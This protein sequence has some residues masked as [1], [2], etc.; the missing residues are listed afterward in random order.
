MACRTAW[1]LYGVSTATLMTRAGSR[2]GVVFLRGGSLPTR[3]AGPLTSVEGIRSMASSAG[4]SAVIVARAYRPLRAGRP[5]L[6]GVR[7]LSPAHRAR[8]V[9]VHPLLMSPPVA[10]AP[11]LESAVPDAAPPPK[12][13]SDKAGARADAL[14]DYDGRYRF[15]PIEEAQVARAMIKRY[16]ATLYERAVSDVVIV[17]AGSAGLSCAYH[18]A[19]ARPELKI[20]IVEASVAPGGGA[21]L[22]GQLMTP[23][24]VRKP[25]DRFLEELGVPFEDEG[26]FVVVK[27][28][29]LFTA[30]VLAHVLRMPNVVLLNATAVEDLIV[31]GRSDGAQ[32]RVAGVVV[33]WTLVALN[34]ATQSCMDPS[35]LTAPVVV[36]AT[37]HDGPMGAFCARR[38]VSAGLR[39]AL[40]SMR[41]L[42]MRRA[43]PAIVNG[44]REVVPGLVMAGMELA[45]HDGSNRMGPTFGAMM[46][47]GIKAAKEAMRVLDSHRIVDGRVVD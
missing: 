28:A 6:W 27:H 43:E 19:K 16:S 14:E 4:D 22:G 25:A 18:L 7:Y 36:S 11:P 10:T 15:A 8:T 35:T 47:S 24:V 13:A 21:W 39:P 41:A 46:A 30:T 3:D 12:Q 40:G 9:S 31:H 34:H 23:M 5:A 26:A 29:A 32:A 44:T 2:R 1:R 33:N 20:T 42:D 17:G 38:L 37:G 45:E